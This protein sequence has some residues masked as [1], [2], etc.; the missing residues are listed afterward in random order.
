[1]V[2]E[3]QSLWRW[4][5][6]L[7]AG[8][9]ES[10]YVRTTNTRQRGSLGMVQVFWSLKAWPQWHT[11]SDKATSPNPSQTV[12]SARAFR[13]MTLIQTAQLYRYVLHA[14]SNFI[15]SSILS[16]M[17]S[18]LMFL[19]SCFLNTYWAAD[20]FFLL[21]FLCLCLVSFLDFSASVQAHFTGSIGLVYQVP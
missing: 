14:L 16:P 13:H 8:T 21:L 9:A 19:D 17:L 2:S 3:G 12:L 18:L 20:N 11:S 5:K 10:S 6:G 4:S 15:H 1:M 7:V